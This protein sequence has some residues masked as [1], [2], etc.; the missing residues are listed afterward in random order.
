M[1]RYSLEGETEQKRGVR[2]GNR[3]SRG[4]RRKGTK[5]KRNRKEKE[6]SKLRR[7]Y[8]SRGRKVQE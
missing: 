4:T 2:R 3:E 1:R 5:K 6:H 7:N 8:R